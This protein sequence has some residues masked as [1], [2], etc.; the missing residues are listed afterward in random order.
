MSYNSIYNIVGL[1]NEVNRLETQ[2]KLGWEKEFRTLKWLGLKN[3]MRILDVGSGTG[4]Y[5]EL[6]LENLPNSSITAL[7]VDKRL[8]DISK[9]RLNKYEGKRLDFKF[10]SI[11]DSGLKENSYD[12]VVC[13][14]VFQHIEN[15]IE[16]AKEIYRLLKPG[17]IV[18]IIDSDRGM[19]GVSD[20]DMLFKSGKGVI[21]Q[22]EK[23]ASWNR[24]IG[25]KLIKILKY[26][27]F[28]RL[29]FEAVTIHS[30][31]V[32]IKNILG[33]NKVPPEIIRMIGRTNPRLA[34]IMR[35]CSDNTEREKCT[36]I[37]LN[38]I[39]KG[40]KPIN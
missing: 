18:A 34:K 27:G 26:T 8:F 5:T 14:F 36:I 4:V 17:G 16:A 7:E 6:L 37:F 3:G 11:K 25:R 20:P 9:E 33:N 10:G 31:L 38:V 1:N 28:E 19:H 32:G 40:Q 23:R 12:F 21:T 24:E 22:I 15:P 29:D 35:I 30:D 2:A 13:R 39:A